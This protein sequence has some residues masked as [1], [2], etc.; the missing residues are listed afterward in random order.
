M[1]ERLYPID[2]EAFSVK[3]PN[4]ISSEGAAL[5][6]KGWSLRDIARE[7]GCSKNK[8]RAQ[9]KKAGQTK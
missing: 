6:Q 4:R 9:L 8:V 1:S 5:Y 7:F 2:C 3:E